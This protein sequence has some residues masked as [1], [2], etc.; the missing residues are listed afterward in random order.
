M[1]AFFYLFAF[2]SIFAATMVIS[3]RNSV[4]GVLYLIF[5]FLNIAGLFI[6]LGAEYIALTLIIVYVGAVAV[7]FLFVVMMLNIEM[8]AV[9][10]S[11]IKYFPLGII[12]VLIFIGLLSAAYM[13][14][15]QYKLNHPNTGTLITAK[16]ETGHRSNIKEL[17]KILYTDHFLSFQ[18]CGL[19]LFAAM[20]GAIVLTL[21]HSKKVRRQS[22]KQQTMRKPNETVQLVDVPSK[23]GLNV[24]Y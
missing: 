2:F 13:K 10:R 18:L 14:Q 23:A 5:T 17:G 9:R 19:I 24:K 4:H 16:I 11:F 3:V 6:L 12:V 15:N 21:S 7:L 20:L 8:E 22:I 1:S